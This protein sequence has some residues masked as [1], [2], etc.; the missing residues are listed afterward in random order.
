MGPGV[1][2][3]SK[4]P[5]RFLACIIEYMVILFAEL[6]KVRGSGLGHK[7]DFGSEHVESEVSLGHPGD[8]RWQQTTQ[9]AFC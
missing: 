3:E 1:R 6:G 5:V 4:T 7:N 8:V 2:E 9:A